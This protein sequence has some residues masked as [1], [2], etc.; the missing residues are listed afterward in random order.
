MK[1][2]K[3]FSLIEVMLAIALLG[4]IGVAFLG[5]LSTASKALFIADE[6]ATA[7]SLARSQ[8]EDIKN[9]DYSDNQWSYEVTDSS[10]TVLTDAPSWWD[11][12][13]DNPPLL[14]SNYAGYSVEVKAEDF[15][16]DGDGEIDEGIR[17]I[18]VKIYHHDDA[19][20]NPPV[21][22]LVGYK[23]DR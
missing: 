8:M 17:K 2:E 20:A 12:D 13:N 19:H 21:I 5:A 3:G 18:T 6:R 22:T 11:P 1:N 15:D 14:P 16:V 10:R 23:V 9:Q 7:E 4:I